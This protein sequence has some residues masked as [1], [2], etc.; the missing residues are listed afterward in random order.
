[1]PPS[2]ESDRNE[3]FSCSHLSDLQQF[4]DAVFMLSLL[5][6]KSGDKNEIAGLVESLTETKSFN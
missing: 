3:S 2:L 5:N 4:S 6:S 1:M